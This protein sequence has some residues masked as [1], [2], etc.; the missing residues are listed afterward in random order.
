L[1][2]FTNSQKLFIDYWYVYSIG[3]AE[4]SLIFP[5]AVAH[6]LRTIIDVSIIILPNGEYLLICLFQYDRLI[7][8]DNGRI[9]EFDTPYNLIH[10]EDS[11]ML[12][13]VYILLAETNYLL[14]LPWHVCS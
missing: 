2:C 12:S 11:G 1:T 8:L 10:K 9:A 4:H 14:S 7:V 5:V 13:K 3:V 6:R